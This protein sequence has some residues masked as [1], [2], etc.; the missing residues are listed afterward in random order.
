LEQGHGGDAVVK[1]GNGWHRP[2]KPYRYHDWRRLIGTPVEVRKNFEIV[3][4]GV[5]DDAM[6]DSSALW[7]AADAGGGRTL[8]AAAEGFEVWIRPQELGGKL[9]F[10]MAAAQLSAARR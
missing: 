7:I 9:C 10:K 8:F 3:R 4:T 1:M 6:E 2:A 5:V